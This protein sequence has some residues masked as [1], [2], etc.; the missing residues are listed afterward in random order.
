MYEYKSDDEDYYDDEDYDMC[1]IMHSEDYVRIFVEDCFSPD[2]SPSG[3]RPY[4]QM[5]GKRITEEQALEVI[6]TTDNLFSLYLDL[7]NTICGMNFGNS[8]FVESGLSHHGWV[9]PNGIVGTNDYMNKYPLVSEFAEELAAYLY[10]FP[11]LDM[12]IGITRWNEMSDE[13]WEIFFEAMKKSEEDKFFDRF[14]FLE[15]DDFCENIEAGIWVHDKKIEIVDE[16]SAVKLYKQYEAEYGEE[17]R[18][19]YF[20]EYYDKYQPDI[21]TMSYLKKCLLKHGITNAET[22]LKEKVR[23]Y[24]L[25]DVMQYQ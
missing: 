11:F 21:V 16:K 17:N 7:D 6:S 22:L 14:G 3:R 1:G 25:E 18:K 20:P 12:V 9:H 15:Y 8:W 2:W 19:V 23:P 10:R 13:R 4:Y 5:R 24:V